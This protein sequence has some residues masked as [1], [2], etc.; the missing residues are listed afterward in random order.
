MRIIS[1]IYKHRRIDVPA[2]AA[3]VRPTSDFARQGMFNV[4]AH[5]GVLAC[6]LGDAAVAD[7]CAG[8]GAL[9]LEALSRGA[10]HV[11]FLD[12]AR[13]NL[14]R[15][16][17]HLRAWGG[18]ENATL[19]CADAQRLP[20]A[21]RVHQLVFLDPPYDSSILEHCLPQ[22]QPKGWVAPGTLIITESEADS[23]LTLPHGLVQV[24]RRRYGRAIIDLLRVTEV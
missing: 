23:P 13:E 16:E 24:D 22:L 19:L 15:I 17:T 9:G 6:P 12:H 5:G 3:G 20:Q 1:G 7:L 14:R 2:S 10:S 18:A 21:S 11:T 8:S 4:L